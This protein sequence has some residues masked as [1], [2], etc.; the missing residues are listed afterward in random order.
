MIFA[1]SVY[2]IICKGLLLCKMLSY[3]LFDGVM[4]NQVLLFH[5]IHSKNGVYI[6]ED[7]ELMVKIENSSLDR[8]W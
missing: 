4:F 2:N 7:V 3:K 8:G 6:S 5:S 1:C